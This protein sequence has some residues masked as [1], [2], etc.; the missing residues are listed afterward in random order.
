MKDNE[1]TRI[2]DNIRQHAVRQL[3]YERQEKTN[4]YL[5]EH[6]YAAGE[7][8]GP[9]VQ[10]ITADRPV[11]LVFADDDPH[12][13]FSHACRYI[14]YEAKTG[15]FHRELPACLPPFDATKLST[16]KAFHEPVRFIEQAVHY[17]LKPYLRTPIIIPDGDRYAI[18]FSGMTNKRHLN[19][20][21]FLYRTLIDV[22]GFKKDHIFALTYD[23]TLNTQDGVQN[24]WPDGTP[25]RIQINGAGTR[26][27]FEDVFDDLKG[28]L[29]SRDEL[30]IHTNNHGGWDNVPGS[31]YLYAYPSWSS[32]YNAD[33]SSKLGTLPKYSKLIVMMEQCHSGGFNASVLAKSTAAATSIASAAIESQNSYITA[34]GNWDPF[35]R[36][37]I[38]T[39]AGCTPFG[40]AL[41]F[42]ADTDGDGRIQAEE[43]YAYAN[44]IHDSRDTPN[45]NESSEAGGD[46]A[47]GQEYRILWWGPILYEA[48]KPH[49]IKW[50]P[51]E[52]YAMVRKMEPELQKL[53]VTLDQASE[54]MRKEATTKVAALV[55]S[56][57]GAAEKKVA[58]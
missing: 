14:L 2:L 43:A 28:K 40:G 37:W 36:D 5:D 9:H 33:F 11:F 17:P 13:N 52:Y 41:A 50:P 32:Y 31:A 58:A 20:L 26:K 47:L 46:I 23:G 56:V 19:D 1:A 55:T 44:A 15:G 10:K 51:E 48:L 21:E 35:A 30:L 22:Y 4:L 53:T 16:L 45:Y 7:V 18:L 39:Q 24:A 49:Y 6:I 42:N 29:K 25:Y 8:I 54:A 34:D 12:A 3:S 38:A 57:F 27:A